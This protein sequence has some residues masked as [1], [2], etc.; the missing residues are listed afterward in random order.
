[1]V[2]SPF[3]PITPL[4]LVNIV[5]TE[6]HLWLDRE[7]REYSRSS[8]LGLRL[9]KVPFFCAHGIGH[10][11]RMGEAGRR[12]GSDSTALIPPVRL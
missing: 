1:M 11:F 5:E 7:F 3:M 10:R 12:Q 6:W 8:G 2:S 4:R 9:S